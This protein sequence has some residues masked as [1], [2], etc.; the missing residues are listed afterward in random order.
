MILKLYDILIKL[1]LNPSLK[2]HNIAMK[3]LD[4]E[5]GG[6]NINEN[7]Q[8]ALSVEEGKTYSN[9]YFRKRTIKSKYFKNILTENILF[10]A[11]DACMGME[12]QKEINLLEAS[13]NYKEMARDLIWAKC[14]NCGEYMLPKLTIHFGKELNINGNMNN[15]TS[16]YDSIVLFSP[17]SLKEN[18]NNSLLKDY[19]IKLDVEQLLEKHSTTFWNTLWY[20]KINN[21]DY[22]FMLP[23]EHNMED[24]NFCV[25]QEI[26][27]SE[28]Y[29]NHIMKNLQ[30]NND[31]LI[32]DINEL[33]ISHFE[34]NI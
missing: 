34:I 23:Y 3:I 32:Y 26:T 19:G 1:R 12:C 8:R 28:I 13:T 6:G 15:N 14:P 7:L 22:E 31:L 2:V 4:N 18:Y 33:S 9:S 27:T 29:E 11:F 21:L 10:Y 25:N 5:K 17:L 30:E 16:K 20:F 24:I